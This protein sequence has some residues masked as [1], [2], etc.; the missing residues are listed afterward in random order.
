[1]TSV[2]GSTL[3]FEPSGESSEVIRAMGIEYPAGMQGL[4]NVEGNDLSPVVGDNEEDDES[5]KS[6]ELPADGK[7]H[8]SEKA[9]LIMSSDHGVDTLL[10]RLKENVLTMKEIASFVRRRAA[11]EDEHARS[12]VKLLR[13]EQDIIKKREFKGQSFERNLSIGLQIESRL[14]DNAAKLASRL[15]EISE[16]L[17]ESGRRTDAVRKQ[18]KESG[19]R[20][21]RTVIEAEQLVEKSKF[22]YDGSM[23][24]VDRLNAV[25]AGQDYLGP[26]R[27]VK[28]FG[29]KS[30]KSDHSLLKHEDETRTKAESAYNELRNRMDSAYSLRRELE[31][32]L[33]P[34]T[35]SALKTAIIES[36]AILTIML[37]KY[38]FL[39]GRRCYDD[40]ITLRPLP[41]TN[42]G[43][44]S[45][46]YQAAIANINNEA[47]FDEYIRETYKKIDF[48]KRP[49]PVT[50][51]N[52]PQPPSSL[53]AD[54]NNL[55][56]SSNPAAT[57][58]Q[59]KLPQILGNG[60]SLQ[61]Q[62]QPLNRLSGASSKEG[63]T[64]EATAG[65]FSKPDQGSQ[66]QWY[67]AEEGPVTV[68]YDTPKEAVSEWAASLPPNLPKV[69]G[70]DISDVCEQDGT[71]VPLVVFQCTKCVEEFG[72]NSQGIYRRSGSAVQVESI[73]QMFERNRAAELRTPADFMYD[74]NIVAVAVKQYF[75]ELPDPLLTIERYHGFIEAAKVE[76]DDIRCRSIHE[77]INSLP[78]ANY[79]TLRYLAFH[80]DKISQ[81][82]ANN[83][84]NI[85]N[86][87]IVWAPNLLIKDHVADTALQCRVIESILR[88]V[89]EIFEE[90]D[91]A[92][93]VQ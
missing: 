30:Q 72:I 87:A 48:S 79:A 9:E 49:L 73:K 16:E 28:N 43:R 81:N 2:E 58:S 60:P 7:Y 1:M 3:S 19:L 92:E 41:D 76:D 47:D 32:K 75:R 42:T 83:K 65:T 37:Q 66:D 44:T 27:S 82:E 34:A 8:C 22:K 17:A 21:E 61:S 84:M 10:R 78:D 39:I 25:K 15:N 71:T 52:K 24:D 45:L 56:S 55:Y 40:A 91:Y 38:S 59:P 51:V 6:S 12:L 86:L 54:Q 31:T 5:T 18:L 90:D 33:R 14:S 13:A 63:I 35:V 26:K 36:D 69:F 46:S 68:G 64:A 23:E 67:P 70:A 20:Q 77:L 74:I 29:F 57:S 88:H 50:A 93:S 80:L 4:N 62:L 89:R 85:Q 11:T 53:N